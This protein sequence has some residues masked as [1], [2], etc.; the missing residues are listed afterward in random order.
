[1]FYLYQEEA[2]TAAILGR[3]LAGGHPDQRYSQHDEHH[4]RTKMMVVHLQRVAKDY[5]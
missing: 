2:D 3:P 1:M 4:P 5:M